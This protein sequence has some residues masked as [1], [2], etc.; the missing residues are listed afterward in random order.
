VNTVA[1]WAVEGRIGGDVIGTMVHEMIV[2]YMVAD[3]ELPPVGSKEKLEEGAS[4]A[5]NNQAHIALMMV[6]AVAF[7]I[8]LLAFLTLFWRR[9]RREPAT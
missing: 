8:L 9:K 5:S 4:R 3:F 2:P 1:R 6:I 7:G